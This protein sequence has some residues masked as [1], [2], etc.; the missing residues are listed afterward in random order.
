MDEIQVETWAKK[1]IRFFSRKY[2]KKLRN[3]GKLEIDILFAHSEEE[4]KKRFAQFFKRKYYIFIF[5]WLGRLATRDDDFLQWRVFAK[6]AKIGA[7]LGAKLAPSFSLINCLQV[8]QKSGYGCLEFWDS[9]LPI[10]T[11][12]RMLGCW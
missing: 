6:R 7:Y 2:W 8:S 4:K 1:L 10:S 3:V 11:E 12:A 5:D 9:K